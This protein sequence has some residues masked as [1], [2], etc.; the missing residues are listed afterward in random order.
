MVAGL[1]KN[2]W[3]PPSRISCNQFP[4]LLRESR[5][6][7]VSK[8]PPDI[9]ASKSLSEETQMG[10]W[11]RKIQGREEICGLQ[12][13]RDFRARPGSLIWW[14]CYRWGKSW[15]NGE[16]GLP[17]KLKQKCGREPWAALSQLLL[18]WHLRLSTAWDLQQTLALHS[19]CSGRTHQEEMGDTLPQ[20]AQVTAYFFDSILFYEADWE[21]ITKFLNPKSTIEVNI[22]FLNHWRIDCQ[23]DSLGARNF[24]ISY[25]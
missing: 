21:R 7:N 24:G 14:W 1:C 10:G 4:H 23:S 15:E 13:G 16:N 6:S 25:K 12:N 22:F 2:S 19:L 5:K 11:F 9:I 3:L 17:V 8:I 20:G 18:C